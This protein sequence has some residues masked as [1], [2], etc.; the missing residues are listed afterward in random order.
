MKYILLLLFVWT[1]ATCS[2]Y[3]FPSKS[4]KKCFVNQ[5]GEEKTKTLLQSLRKYHRT[6]GKA[7]LLD[8]ILAKR[9]ELK[10]ISDKCL[11]KIKRKRKLDGNKLLQDAFDK[12]ME[13]KLVKYYLK[14]ILRDTALKNKFVDLLKKDNNEAL[15]AC[16]KYLPDE[17]ICK[18]IMQMLADSIEKAK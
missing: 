8:Y 13:N 6:N 11:L 15:D 16:K 9:P 3:R 2:D 18:I 1:L 7:T 10:Y 12:A 4:E 14:S 17:G 5:I